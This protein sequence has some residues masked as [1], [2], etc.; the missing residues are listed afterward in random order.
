MRP[1]PT[2]LA[3]ALV[4]A[5]PL[6][7]Q[8]SSVHLGIDRLAANGFKLLLGQRVGL[9][10]NYTGRDRHGKASVDIL[11]AAR[12]VQL[13]ALFS[14]EHGFAGKLEGKVGD[15]TH[16]GTRLKI[17]SLYGKNRKPTARMLDGID[18]VLFDIQDIGCR[19]YTYIS[20]MGLCMQ[21][22]AEHG[23]RFVVLDRPNPINGID[24]GGPLLHR[25]DE[26]FVG[27]HTLPVRHGMT[28]GELAQMF[29]KEK[30][31]DARLH[32]VKMTGWRREY[33]YDATHLLWV[34]P[35]PN[36]RSLTQALLYPGVGLLETTNLSVGR[37]TDTP[38][39][40]IGAPW[41]DHL[42]MARALNAAKIPGCRLVPV[43]FTPTA[44]K[45][46]GTQCRGIEIL[47]TDRSSFDPLRLGMHLAC[48]L[49]QHHKEDWE[50]K[51]YDRLLG[52]RCGQELRKQ[53]ATSRPGAILAG[54]K[55]QLAAFQKRR[56]PFLIYD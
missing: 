45:F 44:S 55:A 2:I 8:G 14:P 33:F 28:I 4:C 41:L 54:F 22:C 52:K 42:A 1:P 56:Q 50:I 39:Q 49:A 18:T 9:V 10:T 53:L 35:S 34:N 5:L 23:K 7:A 6:W 29:N 27:W 3:M 43:V 24:V 17:Y 37:G 12:N 40:V 25:E 31:I 20:T 32:V 21:A 19:F 48:H 47:V 13:V 15:A 30:G 26:S 46:K 38:F 51:R 11:H 36:M 16:A